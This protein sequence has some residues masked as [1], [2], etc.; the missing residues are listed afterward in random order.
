MPRRHGQGARVH[1]RAHARAPG[2][3]HVRHPLPHLQRQP[4]E[5]RRS[6]RDG[7]R[8]EHPRG[9]AAARRPRTRVLLRPRPRRAPATR[10]RAHRE[11]NRRA[12]RVHGQRRAGLPDLRPPH[13]HALR[14]RGAAHTPGHADRRRADGRALHTRRALDRP[15]PARQRASDRDAA[16]PARSGKHRHRGRARRGHHTQRRLRGRHRAGRRSAWRARRGDRHARRYRRLRGVHHRAVPSP[17]A[18]RARARSTPPPQARQDKDNGCVREQPAAGECRDRDWHPDGGHGRVRLG[19][20]LACH[21]H[22]RAGHGQPRHARQTARRRL[23]QDLGAGGRGQGHQHRPVPHRPHAALE[24]RHLHRRMGRH[25]PAL[26]EPA[27]Q[28]RARFRAGALLLQRD[29]R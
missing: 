7:G 26:R 5:A 12:P 28:P 8:Q 10:G 22:T 16:P 3:L 2:R 17:D 13:G 27:R 14:R 18:L 1:E 15:A 25:T 21:G 24:P 9:H 19:E 20:K 11:G 29:G 23:H 4:P 6:G